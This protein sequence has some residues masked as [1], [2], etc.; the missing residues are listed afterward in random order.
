MDLCVWFGSL[1]AD[2]DEWSVWAAW[3]QGIGTVAAVVVAL[4]IAFHQGAS[5][6]RER[7]RDDE[8]R[9][10]EDFL[11]AATDFLGRAFEVLSS[12]SQKV[13]APPP[14]DRRTWLSSARMIRTSEMLGAMITERAHR[15]IYEAEREYWRS[16]FHELIVPSI[17]GFPI[18]YYADNAAHLDGWVGDQRAPLS[19]KSLAVL[20]RFI[21]WPEGT[22]D[23]IGE[24]PPFTDQEINRMEIIG[25][26][27]L[28]TLLKQHREQRAPTKRA[29]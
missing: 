11:A 24:E 20:Y 8:R 1:C 2:K 17:V 25:P 16:R 13:G 28:A 27:G 12:S 26:R 19:E 21:H 14:N 7:R 29:R 3:A 18:E 23:P 6:Q 9:R 4:A 10:S 15:S 22:P 5:Q